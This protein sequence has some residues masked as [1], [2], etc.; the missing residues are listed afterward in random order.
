MLDI[1]EELALE[2]LA[3]SEVFAH[4]LP[5]TFASQSKAVDW[6]LRTILKCHESAALSIPSQLKW[7][8]EK[9]QWVW[10]VDL[11]STAPHWRGWFTGLTDVFLALK[12]AK[13]LILAG[14]PHDKLDSRMT[15]AHMQGK[16]QLEILPKTGH[17]IQED[18][19]DAIATI[20]L[21]FA[22]RCQQL[23]KLIK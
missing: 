19:S 11:A 5:P 15:I 2:A 21:A 3:Q 8:Q 10:R 1:V 7:D 6:S 13:L 17:I 4:K 20:L 18:Q 22:H 12:A 14:T 9:K 23:F 16:F